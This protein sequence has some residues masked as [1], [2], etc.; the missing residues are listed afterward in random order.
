VQL[1]N[2]RNS[3]KLIVNFLQCGSTL[4]TQSAVQAIFDMLVSLFFVRYT[5]ALCPNDPRH[6]RTDN[7][8]TLV[9]ARKG[10]S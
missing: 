9:F 3:A 1:I 8:V 7:Y 10:V 5:L 4:A 2:F 6:S